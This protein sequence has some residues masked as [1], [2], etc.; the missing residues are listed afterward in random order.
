MT[1]IDRIVAIFKE[2]TYMLEMGANKLAT[3][4]NTTPENI[5]EAKRV[6]R[7]QKLNL[8]VPENKTTPTNLPRILLLD[9][10][11]APIKAY[12]WRLWKQDIYIDQIVS[13]WFMLTW[14]A[15]WLFADEVMSNR[16]TSQEAQE[17]DDSRIVN[18]IWKVLN[19]A[20]IVIAHNGERFDIPKIKSRFLVHGLPPTTFYQQIDTMK[21]AKREFGFS[22]NKLEALART[23]GIEGKSSTDF[24]LWAACL[25]G[26]VEALKYMEEYNKQDVLVL[27]SVYLV[28]RPYIKGHPNY[29]LF[30]DSEE[31]VCPHCGHNELVFSGYYY[32]TPTGKYKNFRCTH[33]GALSRERHTIYKHGKNILVSNGK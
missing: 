5:R 23:F 10:E 30:V 24:N 27:E 26:N 12:V 3:Y 4:L 15:K 14:S 22:S 8:E 25:Q 19:E 9:I 20:D 1:E 32:Y 16:L 2:K 18:N 7:W 29:N 17:E 21:V 11:T 13:D 33:C 6:V 28:M 31:P